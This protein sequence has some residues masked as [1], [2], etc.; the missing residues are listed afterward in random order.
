MLASDYRG[1][2]LI[3]AIL[4]N[5]LLFFTAEDAW[6]WGLWKVSKGRGKGRVWGFLG[7]LKMIK[8]VITA[9]HKIHINTEYLL[10]TL[11]CNFFHFFHLQIWCNG[12][13]LITLHYTARLMKAL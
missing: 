7:I 10:I 9:G 4:I 3:P 2:G 8:M 12:S 5:F 1:T 6:G 13:V 11:T